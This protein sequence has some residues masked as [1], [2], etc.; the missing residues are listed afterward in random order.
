MDGWHSFNNDDTRFKKKELMGEMNDI[1]GTNLQDRLSDIYFVIQGAA[2]YMADQMIN[3]PSIS[4][5][6]KLE[7]EIIMAG[8]L[9]YRID[10]SIILQAL[11][12]NN[13][14][15]SKIS[16]DNILKA[17]N[18]YLQ[19]YEYL[20][21]NEKR[22]SLLDFAKT[23]GKLKLLLLTEP[24][25]G[26][27]LKAPMFVDE[28][29]NITQCRFAFFDNF[30]LTPEFIVNNK[31]N[32][33]V[34]ESVDGEYLFRLQ[35]DL[36]RFFDDYMKLIAYYI[37]CSPLN[38][39]NVLTSIEI[40]NG[41]AGIK[42]KATNVIAFYHEGEM[43]ESALEETPN[44]CPDISYALE[45]GVYSLNSVGISTGIIGQSIGRPNS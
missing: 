29:N 44:I 10:K 21:L 37:Y 4:S 6:G 43:P 41:L 17:M 23:H 5:E 11:L 34:E 45:Q 20:L 31:S 9:S 3:L 38:Y 36:D 40:D 1:Y 33:L 2:D 18:G 15:F 14:A 13:P 28:N 27:E 39:Q 32:I 42:R 24:D 25:K 30:E 8:I 16:L 7:M 12:A 22:Y 35:W 19:D 26:G